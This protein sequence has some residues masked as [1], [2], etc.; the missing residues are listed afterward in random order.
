MAARY[1]QMRGAALDPGNSLASQPGMA[2]LLRQGMTAWIRAWSNC[3][4]PPAS[5]REQ[6]PTQT[7]QSLPAGL[8]GQLAMILA[9]MI[10]SQY[11][12][13]AT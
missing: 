4:S 13:M 7:P 11:R 5:G 3:V 8:E 10:L 12:E 1:E 9:G 2:L 6:A